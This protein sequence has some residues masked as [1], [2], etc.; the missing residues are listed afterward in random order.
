MLFVLSETFQSS[1]EMYREYKVCIYVAK[2]SKKIV[3]MVVNNK[4][5]SVAR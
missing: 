5:N 1:L 2:L 4:R 3:L